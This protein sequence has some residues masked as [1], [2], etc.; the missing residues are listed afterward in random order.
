MEHWHPNPDFF[1]QPGGGPILDL[2]PYYITNLIQLIG[3]V[4][5]VAALATIPAKERTI[6]SKPRSR[7]EH[8]GEHADH[9]PC[10]AGIRQRGRRSPSMRAGTSGTTAM[11]RWSSTAKRARILVPDPNFFGGTVRFSQKGKPVKKVP[12]MGPSVRRANQQHKHGA[13]ANYRTAGLADMAMAIIAGP[14]APLLAG[15]WRCMPST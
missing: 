13:M 11:R 5:R 12:Q 9:H 7:R 3:P 15:R 8:S 10:P 6:T 2:G 14:A 4:K 1:F